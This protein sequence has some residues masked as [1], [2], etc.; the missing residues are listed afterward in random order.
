MKTE[1]V[2]I[3]EIKQNLHE[4]EVEAYGERRH[5]NKDMPPNVHHFLRYLKDLYQAVYDLGNT[6]GQEYIPQGHINMIFDVEREVEGEMNYLIEKKNIKEPLTD[7]LPALLL[8]V[9][10]N[11]S[12]IIDKL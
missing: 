1:E 7:I 10:G 8:K 2:L 4:L 6:E 5:G 9:Q 11:L 12:C 3:K